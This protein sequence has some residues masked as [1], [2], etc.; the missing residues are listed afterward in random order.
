MGLDDKALFKITW[1]KTIGRETI[2][3]TIFLRCRRRLARVGDIGSP[4]AR[5]L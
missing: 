2:G 4:F 5:P 3:N 1:A